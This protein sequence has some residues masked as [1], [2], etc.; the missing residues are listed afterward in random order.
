MCKLYGGS[1][2]AGL[3]LLG[4]TTITQAISLE[5]A[6]VSQSVAVGTP[7]AVAL[8][9]ADLGDRTAPSL[10]TFDLAVTFNPA[11]LAFSGVTFGDPALGDQ[12]DLFGLGSETAVTPDAGVVNLFE[13]SFDDAA[14]LDTLQAGSFTLATVTFATLGVGP[15]PLDLTIKAL[16]DARGDP[17]TAAVRSG[18]ISAQR[19]GV[20]PEP[21]AAMLLGMGCL[22]LLGATWRLR[23][24]RVEG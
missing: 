15:S 7:A 19:D 10:A 21:S 4:S 1:L 11:I 22:G 23:I 16:G 2:V 18:T 14:A 24:P 6:P 9:I 8:V 20:V 17:L 3:I 13:L 12:L 5:I